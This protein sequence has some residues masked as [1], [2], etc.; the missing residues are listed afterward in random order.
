MVAANVAMPLLVTDDDAFLLL[1]VLFA[2]PRPSIST[3]FCRAACANRKVR[4]F[5]NEFH[6]FFRSF[7]DRPHV[8]IAL[9]ILA[10]LLPHSCCSRMRVAV[11]L[12]DQG[13]PFLL[14][15]G[16]SELCHRS[17]TCLAVRPVPMVA[18]TSIQLMLLVSVIPR[19]GRASTICRS[20]WSSSGVHV[21]LKQPALWLVTA[22][23]DDDAAFG[24]ALGFAFGLVLAAA[25]GCVLLLPICF[26]STLD[27]LAFRRRCTWSSRNVSSSNRAALFLVRL[28]MAVCCENRTVAETNKFRRFQKWPLPRR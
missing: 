12:S 4:F 2:S 13:A 15:S 23:D 25:A 6:L 21:V 10:H 28:G 8:T 14:R 11:S 7:C 18:A 19:P 9:P 20:S 17:R 24:A 26:G 16:R 27:L 3:S 22:D 5:I 1:H